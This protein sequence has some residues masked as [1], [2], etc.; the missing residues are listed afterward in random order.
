MHVPLGV[1]LAELIKV[2]YFSLNE[3]AFQLSW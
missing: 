3:G 2:I 1:L